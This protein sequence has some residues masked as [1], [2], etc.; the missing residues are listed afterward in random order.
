MKPDYNFMISIIECKSF[1]VKFIAGNNFT[2]INMLS[3]TIKRPHLAGNVN[4]NHVL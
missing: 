2:I 4:A 1:V 3:R